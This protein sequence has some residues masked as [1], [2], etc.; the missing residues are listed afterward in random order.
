MVAVSLGTGVDSQAG[1]RIPPGRMA[2]SPPEALRA[3][4]LRGS[5]RIGAPLESVPGLWAGRPAPVL[6]RQWRRDGRDIPDATGGVYTPGEDDDR[7]RLSLRVTA[8]NAAGVAVADS[9]DIIA[10]FDPPTPRGAPPN[11]FLV[12]HSG[13]HVVNALPNFTGR[14]LTFSVTGAGVAIDPDTGLLS[15]STDVLRTGLGVT[16]IAANSGG[17]AESRFLL[18]VASVAPDP[19]PQPDPPILAIAPALRGAGVIG[20]RVEVDPGVW[21]PSDA[22]LRAQWRR[23]GVDV[24]GATDLHYLPGPAD[25]GRDLAC[26]IT[27]TTAGGSREAVTAPLR[28]TRVPPVAAGGLRDLALEQGGA[29]Y[30]VEAAADFTGEGLVF[31]VVGAGA[32]VDAATGVISLPTDALWSDEPVVVTAANS[33]GRA[34]SLFRVTV[35]AAVAPPPA[36]TAVGRLADVV[37]E[38]GSGL[39]SVSTQASFAGR[40]LAFELVAGPSGATIHPGSGLVSVPTD[41]VLEAALVT[42]RA[43][44]ARG[45]A[46]QTFRVTVRS[47]AS[48][49]DAPAKLDDLTFGFGGPATTWSYMPERFA[50]LTPTTTGRTHSRWSKAAGDGRYRC[51]A[52]WTAANTGQADSK[53]FSFNAGLVQA[54]TDLAG[55]RIDVTQPAAGRRELE[56]RRYEGVGLT[57]IALATVPAGWE[58]N[59]WTWVEV[60]IDGVSVRAR[61]YAEGAAAPAWQV[62]AVTTPAGPGAGPGAFGPGGLLRVQQSAGI[63][64]RRL[65]FH[66]PTL[67]SESVPSPALD[68]DWSLGQFT[69][70][71]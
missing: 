31:E 69:E 61:L 2:P 22:T 13:T 50:R 70:Q 64:I 60:E 55:L 56:I 65:E 43:S 4:A 15:I 57:S 41:A 28:V 49:F 42:V 24:P 21:S 11:L 26:A 36:P 39:R 48:V 7:A 45:A 30:R 46:E 1:R 58:W 32:V 63:D 44:N 37:F 8:A 3:P 10:T 68:A 19:Q 9:H 35:A 23:D 25:D 62:T 5:G 16:V 66:P 14:A 33:G 6:A 12:Q 51:L 59:A 52:R 53:P 17:S 67:G 20:A 54:G 27:A 34:A 29:P 18:T 71:K 38:Q 40:D 47:T